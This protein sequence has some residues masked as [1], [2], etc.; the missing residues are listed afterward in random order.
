L[1]SLIAPA[2]APSFKHQANWVQ[3]SSIAPAIHRMRYQGI[4][5]SAIGRNIEALCRQP[6]GATFKH[7]AAIGP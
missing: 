3:K 7:Q 4:V 1:D 6:S 2:I 5:P